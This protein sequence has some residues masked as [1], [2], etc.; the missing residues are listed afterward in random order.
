M[1]HVLRRPFQRDVPARDEPDGPGRTRVAAARGAWAVGS[2]LMLIARA[3]RLIVSLIALII[4]V[5]IVLKVFSA[6]PG[7]VIVKDIHDVAKTLVG[8]FDNLFSIKNP[9]VMTAVNWGIAA[10]VWFFVGSLIASLIARFAPRGVHPSRPV[11]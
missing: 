4:V 9:K 8:P 11:A 1:A 2:G 10:A 3:I 6:N 7:N 5:G